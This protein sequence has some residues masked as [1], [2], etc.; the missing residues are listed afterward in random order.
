MTSSYGLNGRAALVT[1]G[2]RGI[3]LEVARQ[4]A[5]AGALVCVTARDRDDVRSCNW[6]ASHFS[7][8]ARTVTCPAARST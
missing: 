2:T 4:L 5:D 6:S 1:G 8:N 7:A 3:G